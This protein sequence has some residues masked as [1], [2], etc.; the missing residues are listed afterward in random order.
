[1]KAKELMIGDLVYCTYWSQKRIVRVWELK[2]IADDELKVV[3][4]DEVPLV[5]HER[6]I[7]P[8]SLTSELMEKNGFWRVPQ[9]LC[10]NPYHWMLEKYEEESGELF[11]RIKAYDTPFRGMFVSIDNPS[12]CATISFG[13]QIEFIH[14]LQHALRLCEIN[15]E[16]KLED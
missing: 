2:R 1:M 6:Y 16:I 4:M 15:M 9:P 14:E 5:F 10:T 13:K 8:I 12:C 3:V 7:E 11:Y